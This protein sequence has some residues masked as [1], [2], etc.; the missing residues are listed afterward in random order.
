MRGLI[1]GKPHTVGCPT[2]APQKIRGPSLRVQ[3]GSTPGRNLRLPFS[4]L[5]NRG[6]LLARDLSP[7]QPVAA[8][9]GRALQEAQRQDECPIP[10]M[11]GPSFVAL[12]AEA[13]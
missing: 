2:Q 12:S 7:E 5:W 11:G 6:C 8:T 13:N 1:N 3:D 10:R 9:L 4:M